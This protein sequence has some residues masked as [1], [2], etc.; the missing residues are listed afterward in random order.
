MC[1]SLSLFPPHQ[2]KL[3][4]SSLA[5][6]FNLFVCLVREEEEEE[7]VQLVLRPAIRQARSIDI[8]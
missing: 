8:D 3:L 2:S 1:A 4:G 5:V 7:A 6:Y